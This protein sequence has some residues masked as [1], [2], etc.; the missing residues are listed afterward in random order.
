MAHGSYTQMGSIEFIKPNGESTRINIDGTIETS[1]DV[2]IMDL[3]D[4]CETWQNKFTG[5]MTSSDGL[6]L[7]WLC[8][9]CK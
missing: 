4:K 7:V 8:E 3:C 1:L 2:P 9:R 5:A 6:A